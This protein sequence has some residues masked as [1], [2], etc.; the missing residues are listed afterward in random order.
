MKKKIVILG[1][2]G[3][4]GKS[5]IRI[6]TKDKKNINILLLSANKNYKELIKQVNFFK[7]KNIIITNKN[8]FLLI[9]KILKNR[10]INIYNNFD[11]ID[12]IFKYKK[13]DYTMNAITGLDGLSPTLKVIKY[14]KKIAIANKEAIICGWHLIENYL[15][16]YNTDF[17]PIDSEHFSIWSLINE[18]KNKDIEKV[19]IT[20]SGGPFINRPLNKFKF[21]KRKSAL[22]HPNWDM[23]EKI[24]IDSATMMNKVFETIE[25]KKIFNLDYKKLSILIHPKSY[26]HAIVKF[27]NG[28]TK[29]LIHDTNMIIPIFNSLYPNHQ[30]KII[31]KS[32]DFKIMNK[33]DF[34]KVNIKKFPVVKILE[35]LPNKHSLFETVLVSAND[36]LVNMFLNNKIKF[37]DISRILLKIINSNEFIKYKK[38]K[39]K[40][41]EQIVKLSNYVS[42]KINSLSI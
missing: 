23:G 31:S 4:I 25:A 10:K 19:Y 15:K 21:I 13:I 39:P 16:K 38:I 30:K 18:A 2:T 12:K 14:T 28:L 35:G 42:L 20:A 34:Q 11:S 32:L 40:N 8:N 41:T 27:N 3:S 33:L 36:K 24:S 22:K 1:S 29:I 37:L 6:L 9:K 5:T 7:V 17:I 26:V